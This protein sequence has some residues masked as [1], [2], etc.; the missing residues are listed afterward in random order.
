MLADMAREAQP[1]L[2]LVDH[3]IER[4]EHVLDSSK[5]PV[6]RRASLGT[7][8]V[9]DSPAKS[10]GILSAMRSPSKWAKSNSKAQHEASSSGLSVPGQ[11]QMSTI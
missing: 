7:R 11:T 2:S 4:W 6:P 1:L 5:H 9:S 3:N 8:G 10:P